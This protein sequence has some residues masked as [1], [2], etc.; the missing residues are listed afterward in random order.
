MGNLLLNYLHKRDSA[1]EALRNIANLG[2][3]LINISRDITFDR[4]IFTDEEIVDIIE[5][6]AAKRRLFV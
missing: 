2:G 6:S 4:S 3:P 5:F 1:R